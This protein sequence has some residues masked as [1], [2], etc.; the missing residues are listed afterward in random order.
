MTLD[1]VRSGSLAATT[2]Q[3]TGYAA[4]WCGVHCALTPILIVFMPALAL[5]ETV[6][7]G[8]WAVT[9]L[10]GALVFAAG[11]TRSQLREL[12]LFTSGAALWAAS[13]AGLLEPVPEAWTSA[14]GSVIVAWSLFRSA[15]ICR[16][17]ECDACEAEPTSRLDV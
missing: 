11:P 7:R 10:V 2:S 5:S 14:L 1:S 16:D 3:I 12:A 8:V 9:I 6:E 15:R 4:A 17:G 13:L